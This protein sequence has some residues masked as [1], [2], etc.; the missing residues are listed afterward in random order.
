MITLIHV[1]QLYKQND[2]SVQNKTHR[3]I[4][5]MLLLLNA[6]IKIAGGVRTNLKV[7]KI[8]ICLFSLKHMKYR[9]DIESRSEE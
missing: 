9:C 3:L 6:L 5:L 7:L 8:D 1:F 2:N 4:G